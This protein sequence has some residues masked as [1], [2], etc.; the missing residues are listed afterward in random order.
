[1]QFASSLMCDGF[2][3]NAVQQE[4]SLIMVATSDNNVSMLK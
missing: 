3:Y 4:F 2:K 1:M